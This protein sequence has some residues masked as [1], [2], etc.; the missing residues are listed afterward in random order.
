MCVP[1][2]GAKG[3]LELAACDGVNDWQLVCPNK[4]IHDDVFKH[5]I[6]TP[7]RSHIA[8]WGDHAPKWTGTGRSGLKYLV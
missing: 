5:F 7:D 2:T 6:A 3:Q 4:C 1:S 8:V